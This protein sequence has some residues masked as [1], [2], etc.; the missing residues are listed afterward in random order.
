MS[1]DANVLRTSGGGRGRSPLRTPRPDAALHWARRPLPE[2]PRTR[3]VSRWSRMPLDTMQAQLEEWLAGLT[4]GYTH[5]G[6]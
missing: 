1:T 6:D 4:I 3:R 5:D 2:P